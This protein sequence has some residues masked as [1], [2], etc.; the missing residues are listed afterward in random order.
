[1]RNT[2]DIIIVNWNSGKQLYKCLRSIEATLLDGFKLNRVV[3]VDNASTDDSMDE[4]GDISLPLSIINN[5]TN[6]GFGAACN[7]GST[8]CDA[9]YLLFL[10]PDTKLFE[11]SLTVPLHFMEDETNQNVGICSVQLVDNNDVVSRSCY[12]LPTPGRLIVQSIGL[13][14]LPG[15]KHLGMHMQEWDHRV[16]R[17]VEQVL[18]A[19][20]L[21]RRYLFESLDGFD[22]RFFVYFEEVDFSFR[23]RKAG[24]KSFYLT[25]AKAF[26]C[27]GGTTS[28]VKAMRLFYSLRSRLLYC[29]KHFSISNA[30]I[31]TGV[32]LLL[33]PVSRV[34]LCLIRGNVSGASDTLQG[35][36]LLWGDLGKLYRFARQ[37]RG[38]E[39]E[40]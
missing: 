22:K 32:T 15:F 9:H 19:F 13:N 10:N 26:H 11:N 8:V 20:F 12:R 31:L 37:S 2:L 38:M 23:A 30:W 35:F 36:R 1:M 14:K 6:Q 40:K 18:G 33:E 27:G 5:A 24:W 17:E 3:I 4:L 16:S 25:Q 39:M 34:T 21:V 29:F 7:Q 28:Q